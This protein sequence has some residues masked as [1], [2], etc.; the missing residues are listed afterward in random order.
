[1]TAHSLARAATRPVD[2]V[3]LAE[4]TLWR[5][6]G[7]EP[8]ARI[9]RLASPSIRLRVQEVG[10]GDPLILVHG[11]IGPGSW[12]SLI[13]AM[14]NHRYVV[15][16][17]PGWGGSDAVDYTGQGHHRLA[18]D[19]LVSALDALGIDRATV[20][21]GSIGDV[22]ALSLAQLAPSRVERVVML[23]AGPLVPEV[24]RPAVIAQVAS[25]LGALLVRLPMGRDRLRAILRENGHGP[26]L[27][28][29][30]IP[31]AFVAWRLA[32]NNH[33]PAMRHERSMIRAVVAGSGWAPGLPFGDSDLRSIA[34]PAL[35]V[36]GTADPVGNVALWRRFVETLPNGSLEVVDGAGHQPWFDAPGRVA[37]A[38]ERFLGA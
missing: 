34:T 16:D 7:L 5:H 8:E 38:V 12:P 24:E 6:H 9:L 33:T 20:I 18:A 11:T 27:D 13:E 28:A 31:E 36:H 22:W 14:P 21:G 25:P 17:R 23:G 29:G 2:R 4:R 10:S 35:L 1:M 32:A 26:S 3:R 30:R 15:I 19:I 37:A